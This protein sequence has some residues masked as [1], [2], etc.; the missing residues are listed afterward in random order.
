M[1]DNDTFF[2]SE[3]EDTLRLDKM[4]AQHFPKYSRT[5]FQYLIEKNLV[6]VNGSVV[7]KRLQ[8]R[9]GDEIEIEFACTPEID[10]EPE[11][12]P[13]DILFEDEDLLA[14]NKPAGMVVHPGAGNYSGTFVNAL[15]FHC[16]ELSKG[17]SIRP[18]IVHR[19]DKDT[20][21]VLLAAKNEYMQQQ[22]VSLFASRNISKVYLAVCIGNPGNRLIEGAIG[23]HPVKRKEMA[24]TE[25][26]G[27]PAKTR[28]ETMRHNQMFSIVH[29]FPETGRTHQ[30]RVHLKSVGTPILG[31]S[32][33]GNAPLNTKWNVK[34]QLLHAE[35][36]QFIH[37]VSKKEIFINAPLPEDMKEWLEK[38]GYGAL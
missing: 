2:V 13:L 14:V 8:V 26:Q 28:T 23:R 12:I 16:K 24:I 21:G 15:L 22:L 5:Y 4:L 17:E 32:L 9:V 7:K 38:I 30:L 29:L 19:L 20:S 31:D 3:D 36:L 11:N 33:Y 10:L 6:L 18:G 25:Q 37:P 34:R 35:S 1:Q 27:K